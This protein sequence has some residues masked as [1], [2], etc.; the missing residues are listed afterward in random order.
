MDTPRATVQ[1]DEVFIELAAPPPA[2]PPGP[3]QWGPGDYPLTPDSDP[4]RVAAQSEWL[5]NFRQGIYDE[6]CPT[7]G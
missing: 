5:R 1:I 3:T 7:T 6:P 4:D 2:L